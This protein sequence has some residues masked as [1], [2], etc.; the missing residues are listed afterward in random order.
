MLASRTFSFKVWWFEASHVC[1]E[2][3]L[4]QQGSERYIVCWVN[5]LV[6]TADDLGFILGTHM[7]EGGKLTYPPPMP[8]GMYVHTHPTGRRK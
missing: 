6:T 1:S 5:V 7:V 3:Q 2:D 8:Q 4:R